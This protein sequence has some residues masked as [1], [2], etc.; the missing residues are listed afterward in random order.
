LVPVIGGVVSFRPFSTPCS[1]A[2]MT[3]AIAR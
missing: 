2:A 1:P 3:A